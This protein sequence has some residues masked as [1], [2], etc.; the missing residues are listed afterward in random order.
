ME[1][2]ELKAALEQAEA[3]LRDGKPQAAVAIYENLLQ[4]ADS[5]ALLHAEEANL[6]RDLARAYATFGDNIAANKSAV[7]ARSLYQINKN[8]R[9]L[10][11]INNTLGIIADSIGEY[12]DA[13]CHYLEALQLLKDLDFV[14]G[15][16]QV[17][18]NLALSLAYIGAYEDALNYLQES[19]ELWRKLPEA[20]G[21]GM[22]CLNIGFVI[23]ESGA[24]DEAIRYLNEARDI[25]TRANTVSNLVPVFTNLTVIAQKKRDY[26]AAERYSLQAVE[27]AEASGSNMRL[28]MALNA[29]GSYLTLI[30]DKLNARSTL[31]KALALF[32]ETTV[33]RG[34]ATALKDLSLCTDNPSQAE[35]F[36]LQAL[37]EAERSNIVPIQIEILEMLHS[38]QIEQDEWRQAH[39]TAQQIFALRGRMIDDRTKVKI[40]SLNLELQLSEARSE[41]ARERAHSEE[42]RKALAEA[43]RQKLLAQDENRQKTQLLH[44]AAHDLRNMISGVVGASEYVLEELRNTVSSADLKEMA[45]LTAQSSRQMLQSLN[46]ILDAAA[47]ENGNV[48]LHLT[49]FCAE[50]L[51]QEA[52]SLWIYAA[53]AKKQQLL[54]DSQQPLLR[55]QADRIRILDCLGNLL[56]N[57]IKY[58]PVGSSIQIGAEQRGDQICIFVADQGPGLNEQ[59]LLQLGKPFQKLSAIPTGGESSIGIGLFIVKKVLELHGGSLEVYNRPAGGA[60]FELLLPAGLIPKQE[61]ALTGHE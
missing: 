23:L 47:I 38:K 29:R 54:A 37:V 5:C 33:P 7:K 10:V 39:A 51:L 57:A 42:L 2:Q 36:L 31:H 20:P 48:R 27:A 14:A 12:A 34:R 24:P 59:D 55:L 4:Q 16:A 9:G 35:D 30:G 44:F 53:Q 52:K 60:R 61:N 45:S 21:L 6:H 22:T 17:L 32:K 25:Y 40:R 50:R 46:C 41:T 8:I 56:S 11:S 49:E 28:A 15:T 1:E 13:A 3:A 58:A 19:M 26:A 18:N 43:D